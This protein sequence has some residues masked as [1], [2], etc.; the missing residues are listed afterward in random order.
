[1]AIDPIL[2]AVPELHDAT[3]VDRQLF[4]MPAARFVTAMFAPLRIERMEFHRR[5]LAPE[6]AHDRVQLVVG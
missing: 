6:P 2:D 1:M 4:E 5:R 3:A